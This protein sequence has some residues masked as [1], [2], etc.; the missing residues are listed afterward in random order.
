M[1]KIQKKTQDTLVKVFVE[2][3]YYHMTLLDI[4]A[5][6]YDLYLPDNKGLYDNIVFTPKEEE[7]KG[8][9]KYAGMTIGPYAGRIYPPLI[10]TKNRDYPLLANEGENVLHSGKDCIASRKFTIEIE[11]N[12]IIFTL[13]TNSKIYP[14]PKEF[15][16][17]YTI[18]P[19]GF[20]I[21]YETETEKETYIS[22]TNHTYFNL[23][24]F[25]ESIE[26]HELTIGSDEVFEL[27]SF[28]LPER[29]TPVKDTAFDF[30]R[31]KKIGQALK[32]LQGI[33][34]LGIDHPFLLR[35]KEVIRLYEP[36]SKRHINLKTD[37]EAVV[38][39]TNNFPTNLKT[40][41]GDNDIKFGSICLEAQHIPNDLYLFKKPKSHLQAN[42]RQIQFID[43]SFSRW[44]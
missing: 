6:I 25:K 11:D 24:A 29:L 31:S 44:K 13:R 27:N 20:E 35:K 42:R 10:K 16:V 26:N 40:K 8:N 9:I 15:K 7:F 5:S 23:S 22:L 28:N 30:N 18:R 17:F 34:Q 3:E 1:I 39:Y 4:G 14:M 12:V 36:I 2:T 38:V 19:D 41:F 21:K 43:Y 33:P 37:Y 32:T